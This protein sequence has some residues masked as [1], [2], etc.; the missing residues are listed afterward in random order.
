MKYKGKAKQPEINKP[1]CRKSILRLLFFSIFG[2][3]TFKQKPI[4]QTGMAHVALHKKHK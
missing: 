2:S 4:F 3:C 1:N